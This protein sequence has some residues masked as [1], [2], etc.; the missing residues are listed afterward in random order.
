VARW[1]SVPA[2]T[3]QPGRG[4]DDNAATAADIATNN[5]ATNNIATTTVATPLDVAAVADEVATDLAAVLLYPATA[6]AHRTLPHLFDPLGGEPVV[7]A[8]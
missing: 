4:L 8:V 6:P 7:V 3:A 5:I 1:S 2:E